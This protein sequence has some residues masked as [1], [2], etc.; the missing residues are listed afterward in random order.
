MAKKLTILVVDNMLVPFSAT[1]VPGGTER[2]NVSDA[3]A[4]AKA[5]HRVWLTVAGA[6]DELP[7]ESS[8][9]GVKLWR[10][11]SRG[12]ED[13]KVN[14]SEWQSTV[15]SRIRKYLDHFGL[16]DV[17]HYGCNS[18][19]WLAKL[20]VKDYGLPI[21][22]QIG[23]YLSGNDLY[24]TGR[25]KDL[26]LLKSLG[27]H[28][29]FNTKTCA[30]IFQSQIDALLS[31][32]KLDSLRGL[33]VDVSLADYV[34]TNNAGVG[35]VGNSVDGPIRKDRGYAVLAARA[36]PA[37]KIGSFSWVNFPLRVFLKYRV[38]TD[39]AD[40]FAKL[41]TK[42]ENNP[43]IQ[44]SVDA[45]Y[46]D[47]MKA[48]S[49]ARA[50]LVS[51]PDETFGL[52]AFESVSFG[53]PALVFK[54]SSAAPNATEEF[55]SEITHPPVFDYSDRDW[56]KKLS[57]FMEKPQSLTERVNLSNACRDRYSYD[58]YVAE[59]LRSLRRAVQFRSS[60]ST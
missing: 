12:K 15:M 23:N 56:K 21:N 28:F 35:F 11:H 47:I 58:A 27:T 13:P 44:V 14:R 30:S 17:V 33:P 24:D 54:R 1:S 25:L 6:K 57:K 4:F 31:K 46:E 38:S 51:W 20:L 49:G 10:L 43:N 39:K 2:R 52:T 5:G 40:F 50:C 48:F 26:F 37:K 45:P 18:H 60:E 7:V 8:F 36:D 9:N 59:R 19:F 34:N 22:C 53:V 16:P 41:R 3:V 42:L 29:S 32:G 55:L